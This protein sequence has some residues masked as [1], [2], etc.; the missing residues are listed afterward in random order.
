M[1]AKSATRRT[2]IQ[3]GGAFLQPSQLMGSGG[4]DIASGKSEGRE[5]MQYLIQFEV[6]EVFDYYII[7]GAPFE[8]GLPNRCIDLFCI[9]RE[10]FP[11]RIKVNIS[12][13]PGNLE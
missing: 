5:R 3:G 11:P 13:W 6:S 10:V 12:H 2:K 1:P 4:A 9:V 7:E 8:A